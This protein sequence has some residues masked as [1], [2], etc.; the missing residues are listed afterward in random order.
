MRA[1]SATPSGSS[2]GDKTQR[3]KDT[4]RRSNENTESF[5]VPLAILPVLHTFRNSA[6]ILKSNP[7]HPDFRKQLREFRDICVKSVDSLLDA[8]EMKVL[9]DIPKPEVL[10]TASR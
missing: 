6:W 5:E 3:R 10:K 8:V 1:P 4:K 2:V 9:K 7:D